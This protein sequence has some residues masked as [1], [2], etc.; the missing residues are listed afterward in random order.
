MAVVLWVSDQHPGLGSGQGSPS[1]T[2]TSPSRSSRDPAGLLAEHPGAASPRDR[3]AV[4]G[5]PVATVRTLRGPVWLPA[6][7]AGGRVHRPVPRPAAH[8][9]AV[10][11]R[12]RHPGA[13]DLPPRCPH[14]VWGTIAIT[15]TYSAYVAEVLRAGI[16]AVHPSQRLAARSLGLSH[17]KTHAAR[18]PPAGDPQGHA[19]AHERL[20]VD[21]EGRRPDLG[22]RRR[23]R[24]PR[25]AD[26]DRARYNFTPYVV[27]GPAVR[28]ARA[29]DD[30]VHRLV[31]A[32][33]CARASRSAAS[34]ER[35]PGP[36]VR[37]R[38]STECASP[39]ASTM[40]CAGSTSTVHRHE[41]VALI[42]AIGSGKSTLLRTVNLLERSTTARSACGAMT[43]PIRAS[44][45]TRCAPASA[46]SSSSSTCSRT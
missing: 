44:T 18:G 17:A 15:L 33:A 7:R 10:P 21:A 43:S 22:A 11:R 27:A 28:A 30:P 25:R 14:E 38:G 40:C 3:R 8:H 37:P 29:P 1:S 26:R 19:G 4:F 9:R 24:G 13:R 34:Y 42:G 46:W 20:R 16:E 32:P 45:P 12:L 6:A 2:S 41:V 36:G 23:R 31:H 5:A 39:S 35:A